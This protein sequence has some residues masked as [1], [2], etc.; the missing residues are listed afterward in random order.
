MLGS[1]FLLGRTIDFVLATYSNL[2][3]GSGSTKSKVAFIESGLKGFGWYGSIIE[4]AKFEGITIKASEQKPLY[5]WL[6]VLS[7]MK[8]QSKYQGAI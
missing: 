7:Y 4:A 6:Y 5:E 3:D 8:A 1:F 2:T